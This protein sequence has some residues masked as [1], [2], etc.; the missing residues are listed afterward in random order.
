MPLDP[1]P[2]LINTVTV[3]Q[4]GGRPL[5]TSQAVWSTLF[6]N[7]R[8]LIEGRVPT[9]RSTKY[10]LTTRLNSSKEL[11]VVLFEPTE[12]SKGKFAELFDFLIKKE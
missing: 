12:A 6:K 2:P 4:T 3:K 1:N 7:S 9:D 11:I 8:A 10:L 5:G